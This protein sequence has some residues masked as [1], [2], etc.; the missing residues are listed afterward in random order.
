MSSK[1]AEP[2]PKMTDGQTFLGRSAAG[3]RMTTEDAL[4]QLPGSGHSSTL[5]T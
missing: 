4:E 2:R 5:A 3:H 1:C